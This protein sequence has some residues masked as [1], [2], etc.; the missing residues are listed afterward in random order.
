[1]CRPTPL[2]RYLAAGFSSWLAL[3]PIGAS[4]LSLGDL[5]VR[6][7]LGEPLRAQIAVKTSTDESIDE[8][9]IS[10]P[11]PPS[12]LED[13]PT[14][15]KAKVSV[16]NSADGQ[17]IHIS[18]PHIINDPV[19]KF[20][21]QVSCSGQASLSREFTILLDPANYA[22]ANAF[23]EEG[24]TQTKHDTSKSVPRPGNIWEI[25]PGDTL[26][27]IARA[28][29]PN[30]PTKQGKLEQAIAASNLAV[31]SADF[32]GDLPVGQSL[33]IPELP[34]NRRNS[35]VARHTASTGESTD[36]NAPN[37][38]ARSVTTPHPATSEKF[39]LKLSAGEIDLSASRNMTEEDRLKLREKQLLLDTDDQVA[40]IMALKDQVKH[41][42]S[43]LSEMSLRLSA[44][45]DKAP[46]PEPALARR[47]EAMPEK[48]V[49]PLTVS[50]LH[51]F[52]FGLGILGVLLGLFF[53]ARRY[54]S[55]EIS[56][57]PLNL[58][59]NFESEDARFEPIL[60]TPK[61]K[62]AKT[63]SDN[64]TN[65]ETLYDPSSIFTHTDEKLTLTEMDSVVEEADLY[66]IYGW[67]DKAIELLR[68]YIEKIPQEIQPWIMLLDIYRSQGKKE[69]FDKLA[70]RF[71]ETIDDEDAWRK[72]QALGHDFDAKNPL[73]YSAAQIAEEEKKQD[74]NNQENISGPAKPKSDDDD[75]WANAKVDLN[76]KSRK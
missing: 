57:E 11:R 3:T 49:N 35:I 8:S 59:A 31:F 52:W 70:R 68:G 39:E 71:K 44:G 73:Y 37:K 7:R 29:Y 46:Q 20:F 72:V 15:S 62:L 67:A 19:F 56:P 66:L 51:N 26:A 27:D 22:S 34:M 24:T 41:L 55:H 60:I 36:H 18:S 75:F 64:A 10:L 5:V 6:S 23:A 14:L 13:L 38:H 53:T 43:R 42:E 50:G 2:T 69:A 4:A 32:R 47:K 40:N 65:E 33:K 17:V 12:A 25:R 45:M 58:D 63:E 21:L 30:S 1:M 28:V 9:C 48:T 74:P 54:R 61:P 76:P 16:Q